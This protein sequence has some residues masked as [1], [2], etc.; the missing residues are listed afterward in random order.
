VRYS[1]AAKGYVTRAAMWDW[2]VNRRSNMPTTYDSVTGTPT[3]TMP[4][5][6]D[7]PIGDGIEHVPLDPTADRVPG[8]N[9]RVEH[10]LIK[11]LDKL[12]E[13]IVQQDRMEKLLGAG[14]PKASSNDGTAEVSGAISGAVS[15]YSGGGDTSAG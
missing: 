2:V 12:D 3:Y 7:A 11:L 8:Q 9:D 14:R 1:V 15:G 6:E 4:G 13:V 5:M 10:L